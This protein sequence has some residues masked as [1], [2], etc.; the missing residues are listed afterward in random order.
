MHLTRHTD[1]AYRVLIYLAARNNQQSTISDIAAHYGISRNHLMKVV[2]RL[3]HEGF[4]LSLRGKGGGIRLAR[5]EGAVNLGAVARA[6]EEDFA[7]AECF[8]GGAGGC[9]IAPG[10]RLAGVLDE[11]LK[12]FLAVLDSYTLADLMGNREQLAALLKL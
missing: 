5:P 3:A 11:A 1:Y 8:P 9:R 2:Q 10:C 4:L 7:I 6:T 12:A